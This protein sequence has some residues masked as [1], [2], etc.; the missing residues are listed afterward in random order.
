M[1]TNNREWSFEKLVGFIRQVHDELAVQAGR[2]VNLSL[3]LRNWLIGCYIAEYE[4]CGLDRASYGD[5]LLTE[6]ASAFIAFT[7]KLW[8]QCPH[9]LKSCYPQEGKRLRK[10]GQHPHTCEFPRKNSSTGFLTATWN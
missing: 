6:L 4:L 3:T 2:A 1:D 8:G 7:L 5:S 9:N 10:W